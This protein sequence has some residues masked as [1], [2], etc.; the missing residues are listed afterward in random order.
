MANNKAVKEEMR[1]GYMARVKAFLESE[2]EEV[3]QTGTNEY[4]IPCVD[5]EGNE[6]WL[7]VVFK[8]PTGSRDGEGYD[9]YGVA[10][11]FQAKQADKAEKAKVAAERKA[12]KIARDQ[13]E[14]EERK[15]LREEH[16]NGN[17]E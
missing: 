17:G 2:G 1:A 15:R 3:L 4:A 10:E 8:I 5:S 9:G 7:V 16:K 6:E 13:R 14:R 12:A 11:D